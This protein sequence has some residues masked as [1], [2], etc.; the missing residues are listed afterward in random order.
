[1]TVHFSTRRR[2]MP[3]SGQATFRIGHKAA[4]VRGEI[5]GG[6]GEPVLRN[7]LVLACVGENVVLDDKRSIIFAPTDV[8]PKVEKF[9]GNKRIEQIRPSFVES[10]RKI[11]L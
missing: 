10:K 7:E 11:F 3:E 5:P 2:S 8:E 1:M 9:G 4:G 6:D